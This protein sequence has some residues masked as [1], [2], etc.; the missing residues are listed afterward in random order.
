MN[1]NIIKEV[2]TLLSSKAA[3]SKMSKSTNPY[4]DGT[5]AKKIVKAILNKYKK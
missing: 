2:K 4:G 1:K 5:A 3:Y